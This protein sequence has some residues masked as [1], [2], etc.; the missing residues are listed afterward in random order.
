MTARDRIGGIRFE[1][2]VVPMP[3]RSS[4]GVTMEVDV[5]ERRFGRAVTA[6][7][8]SPTAIPTSGCRL[9]SA[10]CR[11]VMTDTADRAELIWAVEEPAARG[12]RRL[13]RRSMLDAMPDGEPS[14]WLYGPMR[15]YPSR[16]GKA[17]RPALCLSAGRAFGASARRR[18]GYRRGNRAAAQRVSGP[19]RRRRRQRDAPRAAD[20]CGDARDGGRAER[21]RRPGDRGRPGAAT[22][23]PPARSGPRRP[24]VGRVRHDGDAH[25]GRAGDRGRL[26]ARRCRGPASPRTTST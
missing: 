8:C 12:R 18:A 19:R 23:H 24:G 17:L 6:A 26:A 16:P 21:R 15:E 5:A 4:R 10:C 22:G 7:R 1:P 3:A 14:Q 9:C 20:A 25:A 13:I 11:R 2:D